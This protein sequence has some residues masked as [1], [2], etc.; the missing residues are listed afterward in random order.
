[1]GNLGK[2]LEIQGNSLWEIWVQVGEICVGAKL[3]SKSH[4]RASQPVVTVP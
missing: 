2:F 3:W 1:M 4:R